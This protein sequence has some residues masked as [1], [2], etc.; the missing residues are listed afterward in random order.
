VHP[1]YNTNTQDFDFALLKLSTPVPISST[2]NI[3]CLPPGAIVIKH[4]FFA[5]ML[6]SKCFKPFLIFVGW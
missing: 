1:N 4:F 6:T 5:S 3:A 2:V